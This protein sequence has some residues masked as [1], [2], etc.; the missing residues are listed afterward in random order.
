MPTNPSLQLLTIEQLADQLTTSTR[1]IRRLIAERSVPYLKVGGLV[2][3]DPEEITT[4]LDASRHPLDQ[5]ERRAAP[6]PM[7]RVS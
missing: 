4:W 7:S 1:H 3:F 2:R 6:G 5:A